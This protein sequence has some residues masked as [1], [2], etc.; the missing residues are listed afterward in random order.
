MYHNV[1]N[2]AVLEYYYNNPRLYGKN[3]DVIIFT[4]EKIDNYVDERKLCVQF[5]NNSRKRAVQ[6]FELPGANEEIEKKPIVIKSHN[7]V[8]KQVRDSLTPV[9]MVFIHYIICCF[10]Y[11]LNF[12]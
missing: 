3:V 6:L 9:V 11:L 5:V 10:D 1:I 8:H 2:W 4:S 7:E 12:I